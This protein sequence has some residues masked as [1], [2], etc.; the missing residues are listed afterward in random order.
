MNGPGRPRA[1][2]RLKPQT[3][4]ARKIALT[5][6]DSLITIALFVMITP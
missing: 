6:R 3:L 4:H 1:E 2:E 5:D